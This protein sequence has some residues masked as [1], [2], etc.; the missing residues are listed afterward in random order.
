MN[1]AFITVSEADDRG[2]EHNS[3][4]IRSRD[5]EETCVMECLDQVLKSMRGNEVMLFAG[6]GTTAEALIVDVPPVPEI[7]AE[8]RAIRAEGVPFRVRQDDVV[9]F[10][11]HL[12]S[13][14]DQQ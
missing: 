11:R 2:I 13:G 14:Q 8:L 4:R 5:R 1:P 12:A 7:D 10:R 6:N 3:S 9:E